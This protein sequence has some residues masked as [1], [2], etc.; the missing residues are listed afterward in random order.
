MK[1]FLKFAGVSAWLMGLG[2]IWLPLHA[3][4]QLDD[5]TYFIPYPADILDN[6]FDIANADSN[7]VDDS[8]ITTISVAVQRDGTVIYYDHWEGEASDKGLEPV[9]TTPSQA[10]TQ[11]WG[12]NDTSNGR[13]PGFTTDQLKAG[14]VIVLQNTIPNPRDSTK[15]FYDGGDKLTAVGGSIA[16]TLANWPD[17]AGSLFAGAWELYPTSQWAD[18]YVIPVGEDLAGIGPNQRAG[19]SVV[20]FNVQSVQPDTT[21]EIDFDGDG[22]PDSTQVIPTSGGQFTQID[23]VQTG[24][25]IT[26]S[27]PIQVHIFTGNDQPGV[28][29]EARAYTIPPNHALS[30]D[31]IGPRS[32]DGDYW[33][34]NPDPVTPLTVTVQTISTTTSLV[35]P[36]NTTHRYPPNSDPLLFETAVRF[37][38]PDD[39]AFCALAAFDESSAQDWGYP[40]LPI[41]NL[42]TQTFIGWGVGNDN[43][44]P[45]GDESHVFVTA[46]ETTT[47]F[48]DFDNDG[49]ADESI[50]IFPLQ[51]V[52]VIDP[53]HDLTSAFLYTEDGTPF[54]AIWGQDQNA[55]AAE[56]SIDVGTGLAPV[57]SL[58][59]QKTVDPLTKDTDCTG[60]ITLNDIVTYKINYLNNSYR[61]II[62]IKLTD[63]LPPEVTYI[64]N[65]TFLDG[66]LLP[67]ATSG[68][69]FQLDEG[70]YVAGTL[71]PLEDRFLTFDVRVSNLSSEIIN[72][73]V[74]KAADL[75]LAADNV[76]IFTPLLTETVSIY[77]IDL[78]LRSPADGNV[79]AGQIITFDLTITNTSSATFISFPVENTFNDAVL[80]Y[81]TA[82]PIPDGVKADALLW[83]DLTSTFG[84][85]TPGMV[86]NVVAQFQV[87][88]LP[89]VPDN[90]DPVAI[91]IGGRGN[92]GS[93]LPVCEDSAEVNYLAPT[94][95]PTSIIPPTA[96]PDSP[97]DG[98]DDDDDDGG[99]GVTATPTP[100]AGSPPDS[101]TATPTS[102]G[103]PATPGTPGTGT[104]GIG[105]GTPNASL[106][107]FGTPSGTPV[108]GTPSLGSP[109]PTG[110]PS[111]T[112]L[113]G[114]GTP[115]VPVTQLPPT[116]YPPIA[117]SLFCMVGM[118][119][120]FGLRLI[121]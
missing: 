6:Q 109:T 52:S 53:D 97:N 84:D 26:A 103:T 15:F 27:K 120:L 66:V 55:A 16:V 110:S 48:V 85:I 39:R 107:P 69:P 50:P 47:L 46:V 56:P 78:T 19:F 112:P 45:D 77:D 24:T 57:P 30:N 62:D 43:D 91:G 29:F 34:Y 117:P 108:T 74:A 73:G 111:I 23:G 28:N 93:I 18:S 7:F 98:D 38:T 5:F 115:N 10:S 86:I 12:D 114:T 4:A 87:N 102:V 61:S 51:E 64:P 95:T 105:T 63:D 14:D 31:F 104:P 58:L 33:I 13:P 40:L 25:K 76:I 99:S 65:T 42:T 32:S 89:V 82:N 54:V 101:Q 9:L 60:S 44:P 71:G 113:P 79:V 92:D 20:G 49:S 121:F 100:P 3:Y 88:D 37:T 68:T 8:I 35:I 118:L 17:S 90:I 75:T 36:P 72:E 119:L 116:G 22:V 59:L 21:V 41:E 96:T 106:T 11:V 2:A 1:I 94:E 83:S 80:T 67:D 70:G 81:Q